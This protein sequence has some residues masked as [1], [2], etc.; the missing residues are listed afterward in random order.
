MNM[1]QTAAADMQNTAMSMDFKRA[2]MLPTAELYKVLQGQSQA[3]NIT[4][5]MAALPIK[6][7]N[8]QA[9]QQPQGQ[10][11][12]PQ[13]S[14]REQMAQ[15]APPEGISALPAQNMTGAEGGVAGYAAGG[16]VDEDGG[17]SGFLNSK[18]GYRAYNALKDGLGEYEIPVPRVAMPGAATAFEIYRAMRGEDT[19]AK[20][21]HGGR[22]TMKD[23]PRVVRGEATDAAPAAEEA[24]AP[25][26]SGSGIGSLSVSSKGAGAGAAPPTVTSNLGIPSMETW[27]QDTRRFA[28]ELGKDEAGMLDDE[29]KCSQ[30]DRDNNSKR[31]KD[32]MWDSVIQ[33][34]LGM[35]G[36]KNASGLTN[37]VEGA[38]K[39]V[40]YYNK[41]QTLVDAA[42]KETTKAEIALARYKVELAKGNHVAATAA[43]SQYR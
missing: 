1:N 21:K 8:E 13:P 35:A 29:K 28:N 39:G 17:F 37:F 31:R 32:A 34:G 16:G 33:G 26:G 30:K 27:M 24:P 41:Q 6:L 11:T 36:G 3:V 2:M 38:T 7:K 40:D 20:P 4:A 19:P 12:G 22:T 14:V 42:D 23:D 15:Q 18:P 5:A 10:P 43:M 25:K 9:S